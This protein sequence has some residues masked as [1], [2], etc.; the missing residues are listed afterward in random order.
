MLFIDWH[1]QTCREIDCQYRAL[2]ELVS[3]RL[4]ENEGLK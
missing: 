3:L 1:N 4:Q 2:G